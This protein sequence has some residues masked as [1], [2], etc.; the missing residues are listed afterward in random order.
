[1]VGGELEP[2]EK[3]ELA[4]KI[5]KLLQRDRMGVRKH[6]KRGK[7]WLIVS[8]MSRTPNIVSL[9]QR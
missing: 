1:M 7:N 4:E 3:D 5:G 6:W 8:R 9:S 2:E